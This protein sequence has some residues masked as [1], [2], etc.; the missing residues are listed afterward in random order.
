M[1]CSQIILLYIRGSGA[2][3][4]SNDFLKNS[5][6]IFFKLCSVSAGKVSQFSTVQVWMWKSAAL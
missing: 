2:G 5:E 1:G 4:R 3:K 6:N